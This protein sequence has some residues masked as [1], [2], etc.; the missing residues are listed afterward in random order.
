MVDHETFTEVSCHD[1]E[2]LWKVW[3]KTESC[4][5]IQP[6]KSLESFFR[7]GEK[8]KISNL[9]GFFFVKGKLVEPET[10]AG[11]S[12]HDTEGLWKVW[13]KTVSC[14]PI[15]PPENLKKFIRVGEK[16]KISNF[17][18]YFVVKAKFVEPETFT[19]GSCPDMLELWKVWGK[20]ESCFPIQALQQLMNFFVAGEGWISQTLLVVL[21]KKISCLNKKL[22]QKFPV[23]TLKSYRNFWQKVNSCL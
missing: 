16:V 12:C 17:I 21:S 2:G 6:P 8:V 7:V 23:L 15:Q 18:G 9:I 4:F 11:V 13:D 14:F 10:F 3:D 22:T 1:T 5:P 20:T 19:G